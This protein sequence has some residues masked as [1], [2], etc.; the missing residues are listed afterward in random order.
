MITSAGSRVVTNDST[1]DNAPLEALQL[2]V[3][4]CILIG[5]DFDRTSIELESDAKI[6]QR[7]IQGCHHSP[8]PARRNGD[9]TPLD[10]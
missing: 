6:A 10:A 9:D 1:S 7:H 4:V 8:T 3:C 2:C 5:V